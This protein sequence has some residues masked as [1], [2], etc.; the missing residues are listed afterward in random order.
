MPQNSSEIILPQALED[1]G[2]VRYPIGD[3]ITLELGTRRYEDRREEA[4]A[5]LQLFHQRRSGKKPERK[6]I[7]LWENTDPVCLKHLI[8]LGLPE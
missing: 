6:S 7:Q 2:G 1:S 8:W 3:T 5:E 4:G